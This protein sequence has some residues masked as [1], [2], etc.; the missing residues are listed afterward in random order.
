MIAST[1]SE[2]YCLLV[3]VVIYKLVRARGF[4]IINLQKTAEEAPHWELVPLL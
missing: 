3:E 2:W 4:D 1:P